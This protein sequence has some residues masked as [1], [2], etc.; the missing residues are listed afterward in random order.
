MKGWK[1]VLQGNDKQKKAGVATFRQIRLQDKKDN[2]RQ[3]WALY[4]D[5][6]DIPPRRHERLWIY[7][8]YA[9]K[10]GAPKYIKQLLIDLK[11]E[12]D[13]NA[14]IVGDLNTPPHTHTLTSMDRSP[15]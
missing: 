10:T 11:G 3:I 13:S 5:K 1:M 15:R 7:I 6:R 2:E 8:I 12:I 14:I 9:A 4:N